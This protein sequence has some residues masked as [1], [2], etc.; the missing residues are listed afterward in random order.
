MGRVFMNKRSQLVRLPKGFQLPVGEVYLR[1]DGD[2]VVL[3]PRPHDWS[4]LLKSKAVVSEGF[5]RG[6]SF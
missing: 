5:L 6:R 1:R 4:G 2:S 3:S